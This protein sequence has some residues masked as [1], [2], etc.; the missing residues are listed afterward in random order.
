MTTIYIEEI[1]DGKLV[2]RIIESSHCLTSRIKGR[3]GKMKS[4]QMGKRG[5][6]LGTRITGD[7]VINIEDI[8]PENILINKK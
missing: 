2:Y 1:K 3:E 7:P 4:S 8:I 5:K 6:Y